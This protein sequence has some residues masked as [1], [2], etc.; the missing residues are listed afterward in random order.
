MGIVTV[1][2]TSII[3]LILSVVGLIVSKSKKQKGSGKAIAGIII[4]VVTSK[5]LIPVTPN[6]NVSFLPGEPILCFSMIL[7]YLGLGENQI[8]S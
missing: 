1:G 5:E 6:S 8:S 3:G 4:S 2:L 7:F